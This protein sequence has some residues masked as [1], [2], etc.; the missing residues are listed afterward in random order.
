MMM[1]DI[2]MN[3]IN[4]LEHSNTFTSEKNNGNWL[5][6][7]LITFTLFNLLPFIAPIMMRLG[8]FGIGN[9]IYDI[10]SL[11]CHQMAHRSYFLFGEH[12]TY[13]P[14]QFPITLTGYIGA[15]TLALRA[16]RGTEI[17]GWKVAWSDRM[18]SMYGGLLLGGYLYGF[19]SKNK[20]IRPFPI[21]LTLLFI[22]PLALDGVTHLISDFGGLTLGFRYSNLWLANLT[23]HSLPTAFYVGDILGSFNSWMRII[24]G[25]LFG[26]GIAGFIFPFIDH[27]TKSRLL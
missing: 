1:L 13:A 6:L 11:L 8:W 24:T 12:I 9:T 25:L 16:F 10:Y 7:I 21:G 26:F 22:L 27:S 15:D 19:I 14:E 2:E 23:N 18:I 20:S 17:L 4:Q 3:T 5:A